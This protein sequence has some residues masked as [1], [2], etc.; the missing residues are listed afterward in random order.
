MEKAL[1]GSG[2][3]VGFL[4]SS[5]GVI[6]SPSR[7][8]TSSAMAGLSMSLAKLS[9]TLRGGVTAGGCAGPPERG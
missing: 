3:T 1:S 5:S 6:R 7:L 4:N 9:T 2:S 8:M